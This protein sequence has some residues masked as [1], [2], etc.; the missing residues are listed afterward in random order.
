AVATVEQLVQASGFA[1]EKTGGLDAARL[2]EPVAMLNI[3]LGY[4]LGKG[5]AIA[6]AWLSL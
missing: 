3:R 6:P 1:A 4:G 2:I 5:T